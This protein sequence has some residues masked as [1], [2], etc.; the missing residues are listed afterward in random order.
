MLRM[1]IHLITGIQVGS[2]VQSQQFTVTDQIS[3]NTLYFRLPPIFVDT[4]LMKL[5]PSLKRN[6]LY[7]LANVT[8]CVSA[9]D[10][11]NARAVVCNNLRGI[12]NKMQFLNDHSSLLNYI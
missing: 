11:F 3:S 12:T 10:M 5:K 2:V 8:Y 9:I 4:R 7:G 6:S 1:K